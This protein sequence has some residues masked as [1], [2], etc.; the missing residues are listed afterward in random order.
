MKNKKAKRFVLFTVKKAIKSPQLRD[1]WG[2]L[3]I[4]FSYLFSYLFSLLVRRRLYLNVSSS[5]ESLY[6]KVGL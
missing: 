4:L 3:I 6:P 1:S 2:D 5:E